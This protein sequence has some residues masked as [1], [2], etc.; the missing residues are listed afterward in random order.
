MIKLDNISKKYNNFFALKSIFCKFQENGLYGIY[1]R[2]GSGKTTLLNIIGGLIYPSEG[3]VS[4]T[5][6]SENYEINDEFRTKELSYIFQESKLFENLT[7]YENIKIV[8]R[9]RNENVENFEQKIT[10]TL[11]RLGILE[12]KHSLVRN[13]S[14]GEK[15]RVTIAIALIKDSKVIIADEPT[16]SLDEENAE[17]IFS[18]LK[19]ISKDI[20]II[21]ASHEVAL[22]EK[23]CD[24]IIK[25]SKGEIVEQKQ[26]NLKKD[27]LSISSINTDYK[28]NKGILNNVYISNKILS[29][30]KFRKIITI[31]MM[32]IFILS[33]SF[34]LNLFGIKK[35]SVEE[36]VFRNSDLDSMVLV[37][38]EDADENTIDVSF[39][40]YDLESKN[41]HEFQFFSFFLTTMRH[42]L[43]CLLFFHQIELVH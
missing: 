28:S 32:A 42:R 29:K 40:N 20:L 43:Y 41:I 25:L 19:E 30:Q 7:V 26:L 35:S 15:E 21:V 8:L 36:N 16:A 5:F 23:Y 6:G 17:M 18:I 10:E 14:G 34:T 38:G 11:N 2:S 22:L 9:I 39:A 24:E 3:S 13:L 1:G 37:P 33:I 27:I 4:Y 12:N 31:I